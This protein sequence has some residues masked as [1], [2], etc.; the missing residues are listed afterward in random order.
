LTVPSDLAGALRWRMRGQILS[1]RSTAYIIDEVAIPWLHEEKESVFADIRA[2]FARTL[3]VPSP[4]ALGDS[5][6]WK[7]DARP[8]PHWDDKVDQLVRSFWTVHYNDDQ[9]TRNALFTWA[10]WPVAMAFAARATAHRRGLVLN[11]MQRP[12]YW[13]AG[14]R[15]QLALTDPPHDFLTSRRQ[16]RSKTRRPSTR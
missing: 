2:G 13:A 7:A 10:P 11:V 15:H 1:E 4:D 6:Q 12:S 14:P 16:D 5:W 9:I 8:A 3:L